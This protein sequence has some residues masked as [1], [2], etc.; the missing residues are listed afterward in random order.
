VL[1]VFTVDSQNFFLRL[2]FVREIFSQ[3]V[4]NSEGS[5]LYLRPPFR[6]RTTPCHI[7]MRTRQ[8][9]DP[10]RREVITQVKSE[11]VFFTKSILDPQRPMGAHSGVRQLWRILHGTQN[12]GS[13]PGCHLCSSTDVPYA[14]LGH[15]QCRQPTPFPLC[16]LH[17]S[18]PVGA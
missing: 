15:V 13:T 11:L 18:Q 14:I 8:I 6:L 16:L 3:K 12:D 9:E 4:P 10:T 2:F 1:C 5:T 7:N 17:S